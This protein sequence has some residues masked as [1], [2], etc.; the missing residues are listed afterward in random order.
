MYNYWN[1]KVKVCKDNPALSAT[2]SYPSYE[3][4]CLKKW[5]PQFC[6]YEKDCSIV[7]FYLKMPKNHMHML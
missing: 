5:L 3:L 2:C 7:V 1:W 6:F 4:G